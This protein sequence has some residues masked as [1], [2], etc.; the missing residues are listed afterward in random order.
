MYKEQLQKIINENFIKDKI[1][2]NRYLLLTEKTENLSESKLKLIMRRLSLSKAIDGLKR[3]I[4]QLKFRVTQM[5]PNDPKKV[6]LLEKI[7]NLEKKLK[8]L[9][10]KRI[11]FFGGVGGVAGASA[12]ASDIKN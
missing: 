10:R 3:L 4:Q 7:T 12:I 6:Q 9:Q 2:V 1:D 11:L 5:P 8:S